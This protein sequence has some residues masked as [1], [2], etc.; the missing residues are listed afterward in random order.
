MNEVKQFKCMIDSQP[1][2]AVI[3]IFPK[4]LLAHLKK[5]SRFYE[6]IIYSILP[7]EIL[8]QIY[9]L[10]PDLKDVINHTLSYENLIYDNN[11]ACKDLGFLYE[12]RMEN[13]QQEDGEEPTPSEIMVIDSLNSSDSSDQQCVT[14]FQGHPFQGDMNYGNM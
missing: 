11:Y 3:K 13:I 1:Y 10:H 5:L 2:I 6:I 7:M 9:A 4:T 8:K 12:N 14:F